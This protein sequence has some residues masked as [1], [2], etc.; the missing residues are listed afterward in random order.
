MRLKRIYLS[1]GSKVS[2]GYDYASLDHNSSG[3]YQ[4]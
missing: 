1:L 3:S 2:Y 4:T